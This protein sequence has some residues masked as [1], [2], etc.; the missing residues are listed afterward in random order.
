MISPSGPLLWATGSLGTP[1]L[2]P[3]SRFY[4]TPATKICPASTAHTSLP[5]S[6]FMGR[7]C[8]PSA[9][10]GRAGR[11]WRELGRRQGHPPYSAHSPTSSSQVHA[12]QTLASLHRLPVNPQSLPL[13]ITSPGRLGSPQLRRDPDSL[14]HVALIHKSHLTLYFT[15]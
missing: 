9:P 11:G 15:S 6:C 4:P 10:P 7:A 3:L 14:K 12:P 2:I 5:E 1:S 8:V 13:G